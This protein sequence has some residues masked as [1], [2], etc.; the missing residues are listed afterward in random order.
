MTPTLNKSLSETIYA[1]LYALA[2]RAMAR[3]RGSHTLSPTALVHE[4]YM[5]F[6]A[7]D[8]VSSLA[9]REYLS[10][11]ARMM[12][13]VLV[14]HERRRRTLQRSRMPH[15]DTPTYVD[16]DTGAVDLL[17]LEEALTRFAHVD[18]RAARL[19]EL[20]YFGGLGFEESAAVLE[21]SI[22][23]AKRDWAVARAWLQR[24]LRGD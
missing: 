9:R 14:D 19:V 18:A 1:E 21:V 17:A 22:A 16:T 24:A 4:A 11:A 2:D 13:R 3:E 8:V 6:S 20:R 12:R 23:T 15:D 5:R 10:L 7:Q